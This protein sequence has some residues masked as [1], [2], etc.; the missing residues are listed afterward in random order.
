MDQTITQCPNCGTSFRVTQQQLQVANGAV[1]CGSCMHIF[2]AL[3]HHISEDQT[4]TQATTPPATEALEPYSNEAA[5][6]DI[7]PTA[8]TSEFSN[9][10][11]ELNNWNEDENPL[12]HEANQLNSE[13]METDEHWAQKLLEEAESETTQPPRPVVQSTASQDSTLR[14]KS[15]PLADNKTSRNKTEYA[16]DESEPWIGDENLNVDEKYKREQIL[17]QIEPAPV[18]LHFDERSHWLSN[19]LWSLG[20]F[21]SIIML[22]SQYFYFNFD[23]LAQTP[24]YRPWYERF[25]HLSGCTI[26]QLEDHTLIKA[27]NLLVRSHPK[28]KN[29]LVVDAIITNRAIYQQKFPSIELV[30]TDLQG[31]IVAGRIFHPSEYLRGELT[32]VTAM[33]SKSPIHLSLEI[34]DPG[35]NAINYALQ[36]HF[37]QSS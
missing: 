25:C 21:I 9:S 24:P 12:L 2:Q 3:S 28:T 13:T 26:P 17:T 11:L 10:F 20:I 1:R 36:L 4:A 31:N 6:P 27:S 14:N 23:K 5:T 7:A 32:G 18:E 8:N 15:V 29:A 35:E 37:P 33:P 22:I 16:T 30:F 19:S 34:A